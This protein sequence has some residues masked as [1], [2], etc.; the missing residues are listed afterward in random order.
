LRIL[1]ATAGNR[2][3]WFNKSHPLAT[4]IDINPEVKPDIVMDCTKT[5]FPDKTYDLI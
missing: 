2:G 5:C 3:V 4:Y 1:D